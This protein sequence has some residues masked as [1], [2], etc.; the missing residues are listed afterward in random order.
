M[1]VAGGGGGGGGECWNKDKNCFQSYSTSFDLSQLMD[2][3][4]N[5]NNT[6]DLPLSIFTNSKKKKKKKPCVY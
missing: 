4:R 1:C 3:Q 2:L 6:L 5:S